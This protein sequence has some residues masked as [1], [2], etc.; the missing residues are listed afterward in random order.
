M[1]V[2]LS[3][4]LLRGKMLVT[5]KHKLCSGGQRDHYSHL[6]LI[7][8]ITQIQNFRLGVRKCVHQQSDILTRL[9]KFFLNCEWDR[10]YS[11]NLLV[12]VAD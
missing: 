5:V 10:G 2:Y 3:Y 6:K 8:T 4:E 7:I 12:A 9:A 11:M 1:K